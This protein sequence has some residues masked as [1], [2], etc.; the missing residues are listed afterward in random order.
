MGTEL[1]NIIVTWGFVLLISGFMLANIFAPHQEFS[2]SERRQFRSMPQFSREKLMQGTLFLDY[3]E[4]ALEQFILREKFRSLK[5]MARLY[6]FRQRENNGVYLAEN[7][8]IKIEY[9]L[10]EQSVFYAADK[11]NQIYDSYL[12]DM[13]V[14]YSII[15]D[16]NYF[17]GERNGCLAMD[18]SRLL[19][20]M[21]ENVRHMAYFDLFSLLSVEDYYR[22]D[23]HWRQERIVS[24][25]EQLL[26]EM[27]IAPQAAGDYTARELYPFYGANY[28]RWGIPMRPETMAYLTNPVIDQAR[29]YDYLDETWGDVYSLDLFGS[30]DSYSIFLSGPSPLLML[31]NPAASGD[32]ELILFRDSF[33]SSIAPLL[34]QGYARIYLVD[35]RYV[36]SAHLADYIQ[37]REGQD[38]LFL[39]SIPVLNNSMMLR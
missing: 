12:Q 14:Y 19:E 38:V 6:L 24:V 37:F 31:E 25:A 35:L 27:G 7:S 8:I 34:L 30:I 36:S 39:Y 20:I 5:A 26:A 9:P 32:R 21:Q 3:E 1:K 4:Y 11:L 17:V 22:T 29:V 33:G 15:P 18:Y 2:F 23:N 10:K 16:K 28:G 13:N